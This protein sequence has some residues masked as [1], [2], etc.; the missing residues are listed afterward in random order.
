MPAPRATTPP[1]AELRPEPAAVPLSRAAEAVQRAIELTARQGASQ[2]TLH[3]SPA[4]LGEVRIHLQR[5]DDGIVARVVA[6]HEAAQSFQ[7]NAD[8][9]RRSLQS[10]GLTLLRLHIETSAD[11]GSSQRNHTAPGP[12]HHR[13]TQDTGL[14]SEQPVPRIATPSIGALVDVLA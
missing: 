9:L 4:S 13:Q 3:L 7:Q 8:D 6:G 2:A 11:R 5:T 12:S 14:H 10:N 1:T